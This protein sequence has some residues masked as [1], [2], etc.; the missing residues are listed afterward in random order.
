[1][2]RAIGLNGLVLT[3]TLFLHEMRQGAAGRFDRVSGR[4]VPGDGD[5]RSIQTVGGDTER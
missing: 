3:R 4:A 5:S 1:M 2:T